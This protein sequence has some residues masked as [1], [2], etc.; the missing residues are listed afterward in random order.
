MLSS[1]AYAQNPACVNDIT[2]PVYTYCPPTANV[3][4]GANVS[5]TPAGTGLA[6]ATDNCGI[7]EVF[8]HD[9]TTQVVDANNCNHYNYT[10]YRTWTARDLSD[11]RTTCN[12]TITVQDTARPIA[13]CRNSRVSLVN[14]LASI[15]PAFVDNG[16]FDNA[17][18][19][20]LSVAPN[21]FNQ[22]QAYKNVGVVLTVKDVC[23]NT[24]TCS[25]TLYV[26][27]LPPARIYR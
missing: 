2:Y 22:S 16:S 19:V 15:T 26:D 23:G 9:I 18:A 6:T 11:N 24:A 13:K 17:S 1:G 10:I 7:W 27:G 21:A 5:P 12:Q 25:A 14:G 3:D 4:Y 20:V 8:S